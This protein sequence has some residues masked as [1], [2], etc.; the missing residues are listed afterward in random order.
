MIPPLH[1]AADRTPHWPPVPPRDRRPNVLLV[2]LDDTGWADLGCYGS[3]IRT[4]AIDRLAA[5]GLRYTNFHV[6]PLCS[7]TRACLLTGVNHHRA[8]MRFISDID[9]GFDN[10]RG[11]IHPAI[12]TVPERLREA[13]YATYLAGKWHLMPWHEMTPAGPFANGPLG[14]GFDRFYGFLDGCTDQYRPELW[15][16]NHRVAVPAGDDYHLSDDLAARA[17]RFLADHA[18][19]RPHDPFFLTLAPGATHAPFQAPRHLIEPYRA[20]FAEG[21]DVIRERR[22]ARQLAMGLVP[23]GTTLNP[24]NPGVPAWDTLSPDAQRLHAAQQAAYA[25]FLEHADAAIGR[26]LDYLD[27]LGLA[28][29]TLVM[30]LADNGASPE[31][32]DDGAVDVNALYSGVREPVAEQLARIDA[33]GGPAGGAHY[34]LGWAM[35]GNTP[36]RL[37][38][39]FADLGGVRAPL[40]VR[41]PS[42]T[43]AGGIRRQFAHAI[44]IG[45][46]ILDTAGVAAPTVDGASLAATFTDAEAPA[47]R[48][49]QY[50]E[51]AGHR[52]LW[53]DGWRAVTE[54][55][56][57]DD[58]ATERWRLY[59]TIADFAETT[60][61]A[62]AN[63]ARHEAM[64]ARWWREAI[65][66]DVLPLDDRP[67]AKIVNE[68][69]SPYDLPERTRVVLRPEGS[70][71]PVASGI[72]GLARSF[73]ATAVLSSRQAGE[74]GVLLSS[75]DAA[76]GYL[77]SV[78]QDRLCFERWCLGA[79]EI[80]L[81][82]HP[83][84]AGDTQVELRVR[85]EQG[86]LTVAL[87][88]PGEA[89]VQEE[90][91]RGMAHPSFTGLTVGRRADGSGS[92]LAGT[93]DRV[94]LVFHRAER[95]AE[96]ASL[97]AATE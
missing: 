15:E 29:D 28:E 34:P 27:R 24:R 79:H 8:G 18:T 86:A 31:G 39:Q 83:L 33:I 51:M 81:A 63:L 84:D 96:V 4:P 67:L 90:L 5:G 23:P 21:W 49:T 26:V 55:V 38:K 45:A 87:V 60:D 7:P 48:A 65:D 92:W 46:T 93:L 32:R 97:I 40:V 35:A 74:D 9:T 94:E 88:Q 13:G 17:I 53:Q 20:V 59:D 80:V 3:E 64:V 2:V 76:G 43:Q 50:W 77:W 91:T 89:A 14:R 30:V 85:S 54:H 78:R 69:G 95:P 75:G 82:E 1:R 22:F 62:Q 58:Y 19:Y 72:A 44:D 68:T 12:P 42:R 41:W 36:F 73:T 57:G 47:P 70:D 71:V 16:D 56:P 66:N 10:A 61:V 25:G 52:A 6:T 11:R 37:Y